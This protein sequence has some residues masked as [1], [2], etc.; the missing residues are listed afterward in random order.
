M[1]LL[2]QYSGK[3]LKVVVAVPSPGVWLADFGISLCG[4]M[5]A[6]V[7]YRIANV[8]KQEVQ[9]FASMGSM[10]PRMRM[11]AVMHA[12]ETKA[13]YLLMIDSDHRFPR[14]ALHQLLSH[15]KDVV[16]ANC[17]TKTIPT[18]PTA[19]QRAERPDGEMVISYGKSGIEKVWRVG[20]GMM[21]VHMGVFRNIGPGVFDMKWRPELKTFQGEDWSMCEAMEKA[22]YDIWVDHDLSNEVTH[23]GQLH[24]EHTM[25]EA[26]MT[27]QGVLNG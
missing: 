10:L 18:K 27:S 25:S 15:G 9:L 14:K 21:L 22:G 24:Y 26:A 16:A 5:T 13:D 7:Q 4:L 20:T 11:E 8:A 2:D 19:R 6:S 17:V 1:N 12:L 23:I 3:D